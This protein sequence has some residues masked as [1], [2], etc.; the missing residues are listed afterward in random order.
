MCQASEERVRLLG[1]EE[2]MRLAQIAALRRR[3]RE[4]AAVLPAPVPEPVA[5]SRRLEGRSATWGSPTASV[6][7]GRVGSSKLDTSDRVV[8]TR[9]RPR[10]SASQSLPAVPVPAIPQP[11]MGTLKAPHEAAEG[12]ADTVRWYLNRISKQRLLTPEEVNALSA[13]IQKLLRWEEARAALDDRLERLS[14]DD[15]AAQELGVEGGVDAYRAELQRIRQAK[16]VLVSANLRLVVSIAKK[17]MNRGLSLLDLVQEGSMGLIKAAER[18]DAA[19]G[20]RLSTYATWWI[21]QAISRALADQSR[22]IRLPVHMHDHVHRLNR[23]RQE[24]I[25]LLGRAPTNKEL[26]ER[27][28]LPLEKLRKVDATSEL[29][30]VSINSPVKSLMKAGGAGMTLESML[31]DVRAQPAFEAEA[32]AMAEDVHKLMDV[33][34]T[35]RE[36]SVLR[37]R[38]G[39]GDG[40]ARTLEEIGRGLAVSR[41]RVRQIESRAFDKLKE[42]RGKLAEYV[43]SDTNG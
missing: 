28:N 16:E 27:M 38:Y 17:Y 1:A 10:A 3:R 30:T 36:R 7:H 41:E 43:L 31:P 18:F 33:A 14:T 29:N 40:R 12:G 21:R 6:Y 26:A 37:L 23:Q 19:K 20:F 4:A 22:T 11:P 25:H 34:L 35:E 39:I 24:L 8:G 32:R 13:S 2:R 15:E 42:R 5:A 9:P